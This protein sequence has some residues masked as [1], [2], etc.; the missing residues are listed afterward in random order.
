MKKI[1]VIAAALIFAICGC[2][3]ENDIHKGTDTNSVRCEIYGVSSSGSNLEAYTAYLA[4]GAQEQIIVS[5]F[6]KMKENEPDAEINT[7]VPKDMYINSLKIDSG[8]LNIDLSSEYNL[9]NLSEELAF[10]AAAVYTF[11]SL[12]FID[13]VCITVDGNPLK[14]TNGQPVGKLGRNDIIIDGNISAEPTNYEMLK[15]YFGSVDGTRLGTEIR[16]VEVNPNQPIEKYVVEQ[17]I[18]GPA[19]DDLKSVIPSDTK[20]RDISTADGICYVDLSNDFIVKQ[21]GNAGDCIA[22]VYSIV[23][24]LGEVEGVDKVQF[25]IEGERTDI[26]KNTIDLSKPIEPNYDI[27]FE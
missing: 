15:L 9:M 13:Y 10:R 19:G 6:D 7:T 22:A 12:D 14:M 25:L 2:E 8:T 23:N 11:T 17:L 5:A 21:L 27:A 1:R 26:Y 3:A 20:I 24:S 18:K 4:G 16:E